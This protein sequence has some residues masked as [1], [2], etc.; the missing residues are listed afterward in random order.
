MN[1]LSNAAEAPKTDE[2]NDYFMKMAALGRGEEPPV[3]EAVSSVEPKPETEK[4]ETPVEESKDEPKADDNKIRSDQEI[5]EYLKQ[6]ALDPNVLNAAINANGDILPEHYTAL[7]ALGLPKALIK[8]HVTLARSK[9]EAQTKDAVSHAGG[10]DAANA[11]MKWAALNLTTPEKAFYNQMLATQNYKVA[12]DALKGRMAAENPRS[13]EG[14]LISNVP[15][16]RPT[17][18]AGYRFREEMQ[19]DMASPQ[20][21]KDPTFR[22]QVMSKM[23]N[24]SW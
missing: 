16:A 19:R 15:Q 18:P 3:E 6:A 7:E 1:D 11:M 5:G 12:I 24:A 17:P 23:R 8:E 10:E 21:F 22:E 9:I 2:S 14:R 20:Y 13:A 4:A